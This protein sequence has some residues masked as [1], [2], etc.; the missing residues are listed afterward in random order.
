M[1]KASTK[2]RAKSHLTRPASGTAK[3]PLRFGLSAPAGGVMFQK[4][5]NE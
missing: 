3:P 4:E 1:Q 2:G 5:F